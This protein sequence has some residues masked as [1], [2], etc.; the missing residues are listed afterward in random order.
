MR[1]LGPQAEARAEATLGG[2][3]RLS[4]RGPAPEAAMGAASLLTPE[5]GQFG[6]VGKR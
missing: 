2:G 3:Q 5:L 1:G 6:R 4:P